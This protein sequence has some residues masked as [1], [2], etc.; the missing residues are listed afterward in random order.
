M[1]IERKWLIIGL[2]AASCLW[3]NSASV[4]QKGPAK[5]NPAPRDYP[6]KPVPFTAV[7]FNDVF[8]APRIE[9]NRT[10]TIPFAFEKCEETKRIY[11]FERAAAALRGEEAHGQETAR[12]PLRRHRSVQGDRRRLV[13]AQRPTRPEARILSRQLDREDRRG[14]GEGRLPLHD[15]H[16]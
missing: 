12:L 16:D 6:V 11:H 3:A 13:L 5:A 2:A 15:P 8:W 1:K 4:A 10:V 7:H 9:I 14:P